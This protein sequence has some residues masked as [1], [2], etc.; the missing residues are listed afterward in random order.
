MNVRL[1]SLRTG[2][3]QKETSLHGWDGIVV[4]GVHGKVLRVLHDN[5]SLKQLINVL[6]NERINVKKQDL[7]HQNA[8]T[9]RICR[10]GVS[11]Y[12]VVRHQ[13]EIFWGFGC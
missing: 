1:V 4:M 9:S 3:D 2:L 12:E 10:G 11:D 7:S 6:D 8:S 13:C 5:V